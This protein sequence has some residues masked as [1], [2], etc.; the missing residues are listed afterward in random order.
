MVFC[1]FLLKRGLRFLKGFDS[2]S[3]TV[4]LHTCMPRGVRILRPYKR[5][6]GMWRWI[7]SHFR[8]WIDYNG[9][10]HFRI[11]G[12][13][14]FFIFMVSKCTRMFVLQMKSKV[15]FIHYPKNGSINKNRKW[16][17]WD[18]ENYNWCVGWDLPCSIK[19]IP[20]KCLLDN[21]T[22]SDQG[23]SGNGPWVSVQR[24]LGRVGEKSQDPLRE[25]KI[26]PLAL[27]YES[28]RTHLDT[29]KRQ[30][31]ASINQSINQSIVYLP[32]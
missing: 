6:M 23:V 20:I 15:F 12:V 28:A 26:A 2:C 7:G 1:N 10:V 9:V 22:A 25:T 3:Y 19:D 16:L 11:F 30:C 24:S 8:E 13:R 18:R 17:S 21:V 5:L 29:I 31:L 4:T 14:Q 32:M 27:D